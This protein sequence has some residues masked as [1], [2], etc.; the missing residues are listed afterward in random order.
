M[1]ITERWRLELGYP[2]RQEPFRV[3]DGLDWSPDGACI[4]VSGVI[5]DEEY[6]NSRPASWPTTWLVDARTGVHDRS[7]SGSGMPVF[8]AD[9]T[10]LI[11][12]EDMRS[13]S[14]E[15][16]P[17]AL[18]HT[19]TLDGRRMV[20]LPDGRLLASVWLPEDIEL[21]WLAIWS[22]ATRAHTLVEP[23]MSA[24]ILDVT[25][26]PDGE[27]VAALSKAGMVWVWDLVRGGTT[28]RRI[29]Q[30]TKIPGAH[31]GRIQWIEP[32]RILVAGSWSRALHWLDAD[33]LKPEATIQMPDAII[34]A[35]AWGKRV[36]VADRSGMLQLR[37]GSEEIAACKPEGY[38]RIEH[39]R[40]SPDGRALAGLVSG[41]HSPRGDLALVRW[42][43]A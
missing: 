36:A 3:V 21:R 27:R 39:L 40:F 8:S 34:A 9:G 25:A 41:S 18:P 43:L 7:L 30:P 32:E 29:S 28:R 26:S 1:M 10:R 15:E 11:L 16:G 17:V 35:R 6:S 12:A 14:L 37:E 19:T 22:P 31:T 42:E 23:R 4:A 13:W 24:S 2:E 38:R 33:T 5:V 20:E